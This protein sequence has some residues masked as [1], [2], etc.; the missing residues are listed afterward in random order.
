MVGASIA[1]YKEIIRVIK[2]LLDT[3]NFCLKL[4][5]NL[6]NENWDLVVYNDSDWAA[7]VEN[8]IIV[9]GFIIYLLGVPIYWSSKGQLRVTLSNIE[10]EYVAMSDAVKEI[11]FIFNLLIDI[12]IPVKSKSSC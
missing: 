11:R 5:L 8:Q 2:F 9:T 7:D 10:A 3:R 1:A 6:D 12:G 4:K